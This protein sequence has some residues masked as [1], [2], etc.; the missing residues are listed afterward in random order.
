MD[1]RDE[2]GQGPEEH[3]RDQDAGV[4]EHMRPGLQSGEEVEVGVIEEEGHEDHPGA[5]VAPSFILQLLS[6]GS[7][8]F[9]LVVRVRV[10]S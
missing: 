10:R 5:R 7:S 4:G 8:R 9:G 1:E 3:H 2:L 6:R